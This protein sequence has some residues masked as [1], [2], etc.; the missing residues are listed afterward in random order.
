MLS[1]QAQG[2]LPANLTR[3]RPRATLTATS[4]ESG[5]G[6]PSCAPEVVRSEVFGLADSLARR[7]D[8]VIRRELRK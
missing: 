5:W 4:H 8:V 3:G 6:V 7:D 2:K 1:L